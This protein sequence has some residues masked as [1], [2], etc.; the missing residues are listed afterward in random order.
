M[1]SLRSLFV[2]G[3]LLISLSFCWIFS[4]CNNSG[5]YRQIEG[6]IWN[7]TFHITYKGPSSLADSIYP[8][9]EEVSKSLSIFDKESLVSKLNAGDSVKVDKNL[10]TVYE[11]S[12]EINRLSGGMF[13]PTVSPLIDAWGFGVGHTSTA[14]TLAIDSLLQFVGIDKT[15]LRNGYIVKEQRATQFNFSAIAKGYGCD[16]IGEM[17]RRNGVEDFMIEV[18]GEL[19]LSGKSPSGSEWRISVDTPTEGDNLQHSAAMILKITDAGIATSGNYRNYSEK[20]GVR[21]AH[22]ISP[23]TGRPF[24]SEI[25]SATVVAPTCMEADA[26]ATACMASTLQQAKKLLQS[27]KAEGLLILG[28]S[29][30]MTPGF[31]RYINGEVSEPGKRDRN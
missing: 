8:V 29:L 14:D 7:T 13:D 18:G 9:F 20:D 2:A 30:W 17:F 16:A 22:T 24:F 21:L 28:D 31:G 27:Y 6:M 26:L 15:M 12:G 10:L 3:F 1:K 23:A 25:L 11:K 19:T 5:S 4:G